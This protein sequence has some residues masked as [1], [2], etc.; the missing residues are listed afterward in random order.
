MNVIALHLGESGSP[1]AENQAPVGTASELRGRGRERGEVP[2]AVLSFQ[3]FLWFDGQQL[4]VNAIGQTRE[5][6]I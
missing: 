5:V 6:H 2:P 4:N 1:R 3:C